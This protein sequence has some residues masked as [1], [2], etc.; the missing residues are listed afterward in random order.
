MRNLLAFLFICVAFSS[1][2]ANSDR[3]RW[4][5]TVTNVAVTGYSNVVNG[6]VRIFTNAHSGTA[7]LTNL[8]GLNGTA[9][10]LWDN[11][12]RFTIGSGVTHRMTSTNVVE[13]TAPLG[14]TLSGSVIGPWGY[15]VLSTQSGPT[16]FTALWPLE[17]MVGETNRTNQGSSLVYGMGIFSTLAFP[18]NSTAN[19]N[20]ITKGASVGPQHI[21]TELRISGNINNGTGNLSVSNLVNTGNAIRSPGTGGNSFQAGSNAVAS[22][23]ISLAIGNDSLASSNAALAVGISAI[24]TNEAGVAVGNLARTSGDQGTAVGYSALAG[25]NSVAVGNGA[26]SAAGSISVGQDADTSVGILSVAVGN[27][28]AS[29]ANYGTAIGYASAV[30][31]ANSSAVGYSAA[32]TTTNQIRLGTSAETVSIPGMLSAL[33]STNSSLTGTSTVSGVLVFTPTSNTGLANGYNAG[34]ALDAAHVLISGPS[35][36]YTNVGF[37]AANKV[38]GK[39]V[40]AQFDNPGLSMTFLHDSGLDPGNSTNRIYTGTGALVNSTN[41]VV[42]VIMSYDNVSTAWRI[43]SFR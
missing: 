42:H 38:Q 15:G 2:A 25:T 11:Y 27:Q 8:T 20:F 26:T 13:F 30:T 24:A 21:I 5:V 1:G 12:A 4:T 14:A 9:T 6:T 37:S 28:A 36:A 32:T 7:I 16:T 22:G 18:T 10:N 33:T 23:P 35:A 17:N 41:R 3:I 34:V 29:S 31:H 19:S 40:F 39:M 43:W